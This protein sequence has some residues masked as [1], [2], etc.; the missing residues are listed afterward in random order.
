MESVWIFDDRSKQVRPDLTGRSPVAVPFLG[1]ESLLNKFKITWTT[2]L[3][4]SALT[5]VDGKKFDLM[6][7]EDD[8]YSTEFHL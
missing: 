5:E 4:F 7:F 6:S 3:G 8:V 1:R 2:E